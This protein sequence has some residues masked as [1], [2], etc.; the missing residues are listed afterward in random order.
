MR[1]FLNT[2]CATLGS[3]ATSRYVRALAQGLPQ[4]DRE[5]ELTYFDYHW[6]KVPFCRQLPVGSF[7]PKIWPIP[8]RVGRFL[9]QRAPWLGWLNGQHDLM[10]LPDDT[11]AE[12]R[13]RRSL[14]TLHMGGPLQRPDL[15][16]SAQVAFVRGWVHQVKHRRDGMITVSEHLRQL[17]I[18]DFGFPQDRIWAIPLGIDD[19]FR[20]PPLPPP[21]RPRLLFV[22]WIRAAKNVPAVCAVFRRLLDKH[23]D[24]E[25]ML[26]G[27]QEVSQATLHQWLGNDPRAIAQTLLPGQIPLAGGQLTDCYQSAS[28]FLFPT[29]AEGWTSPPLE[30]MACGVPVVVSNASSLPETV[31]EA[32]LMAG[33]DDHDDLAAQV[34]RLLSDGA[35]RQEMVNRGLRRAREITWQSCVEKTARL[36]RQ[37]G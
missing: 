27:K 2:Q 15:F 18:A 11:L 29:Y 16:D 4:V 26:V 36:Y 35:L 32:A 19:M 14:A 20:R 10:H 21:A 24:L 28:V 9:F 33:P 12:C 34:D 23:P 31:G 13:A 30:A 7:R 37:L 5:L 8:A 1:L 3:S 17:V 25:L 6:H 22:G